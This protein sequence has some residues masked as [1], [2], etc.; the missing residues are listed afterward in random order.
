M[1]GAP[2]SELTRNPPILLIKGCTV[3]SAARK[4]A[5]ELSC[6]PSF[7]SFISS[8]EWEKFSLCNETGVGLGIFIVITPCWGGGNR[9][10]AILLL[11]LAIAAMSA[12]AATNSS[13]TLSSGLLRA[14]PTNQPGYVLRTAVA[15]GASANPFPSSN[16]LARLQQGQPGPRPQFEMTDQRLTAKGGVHSVVF[17]ANL[18]QSGAIAITLPDQ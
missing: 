2:G 1:D 16:Y 3:F 14:S 18:N 10:I 7:D 13:P 8:F 11:T 17:D 15:P 5:F 9:R 6:I 12:A 4:K